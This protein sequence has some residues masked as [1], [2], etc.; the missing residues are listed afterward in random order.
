L[1]WYRLRHWNRNWDVDWLHLPNLESLLFSFHELN[2]S[3]WDPSI[4]YTRWRELKLRRLRVSGSTIFLLQ[5]SLRR[6]AGTRRR[7][8]YWDCALCGSHFL[9]SSQH[10]AVR[11]PA[12]RCSLFA[13]FHRSLQH[14]PT[15][16]LSD[17]HA[18]SSLSSQP[19]GTVRTAQVLRIAATAHSP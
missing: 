7:F 12:A 3:W 18:A 11:Q 5:Q 8:A 10:S 4:L 14:R 15:H 1:H 19:W 17:F 16:I 6:H 13:L 2:G 9:S